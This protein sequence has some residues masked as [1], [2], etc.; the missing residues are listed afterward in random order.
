MR[1]MILALVVLGA[2]TLPS[3][4][5][6]VKPAVGS[7]EVFWVLTL[8][9]EPGQFDQMKQL[10]A[11]IVAAAQK[12]PGTLEYEWNVNASQ[13]TIAVVER[14]ADSEALIEHGKGFGAFARQF[15]A[16]AKPS[17]FLVFGAPDA[18]AKKAIAGLNPVYM[19]TFDGFT[20]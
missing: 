16:L 6:E 18:A 13:D 12:D 1:A 4:A 9:V 5:Q 11:Q 14:Y 7:S 17:S 10:V 15:F 19:T 2:M 3:V 20:R 8:K